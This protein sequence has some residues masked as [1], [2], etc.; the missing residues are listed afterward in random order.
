MFGDVRVLRGLHLQVLP[1][2]RGRVGVR[3]A[4]PLLAY[5]AV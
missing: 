3:V 2:W 1:K 5:P 4:E